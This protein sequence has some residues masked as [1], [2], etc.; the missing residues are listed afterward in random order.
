[1]AAAFLTDKNSNKRRVT[2]N[3]TCN[4]GRFENRNCKE[5]GIGS[6]KRKTNGNIKKIKKNNK[7]KRKKYTT[8]RKL[9]KRQLYSAMT[10]AGSAEATSLHKEHSSL[11]GDTGTNSKKTPLVVIEKNVQNDYSRV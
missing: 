9:L 5:S 10:N 1:M 8:G 6:I 4:S 3:E 11:P 2:G 7:K